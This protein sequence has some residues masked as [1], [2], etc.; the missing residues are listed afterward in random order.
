MKDTIIKLLRSIASIFKALLTDKKPNQPSKP[1]EVKTK[2]EPQ[3]SEKP[4]KSSSDFAVTFFNTG[5][6]DSILIEMNGMVI[7]NDTADKDDYE[8][9]KK[10]LDSKKIKTIDYL[11]ISHFHKDHIG[12]AADIIANFE[13]KSV[14]MPDYKEDSEFYKDMMKQIKKREVPLT[15]LH[16]KQKL[17]IKGDSIVMYPPHKSKYDDA[18]DFS[19]ITE[20]NYKKTSMLLMGDALKERVGEFIDDVSLDSK[21]YQLVKIPHH[22][23]YC[24]KLPEVIEKTSPK[25]AVITEDSSLSRTEDKLLDM[26]KGNNCRVLFT[27]KGKIVTYSD[28]TTLSIKQ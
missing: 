24:K 23:A 28:G 4:E 14:F 19:I 6:S 25:Y 12:S 5:K 27:Y 1:S 26:L 20:V 3:K 22:G 8:M 9:I 2:S 16:K 7:L 18:N 15:L 10:A 21:A 11:I 17:N 13:V